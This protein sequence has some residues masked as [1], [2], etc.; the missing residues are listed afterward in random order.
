M[1]SMVIENIYVAKGDETG[2]LNLSWDSLKEAELYVIQYRDI[3]YPRTKKINTDKKS[4]AKLKS[5]WKVADITNEP[6]YTIKGLK[7]KRKYSFRV[8]AVNSTRQGPWSV[9]A[10]KEI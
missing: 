2:E 5:L 7:S 10:V 8:A 1:K 9:T 3:K 6:K 4:G